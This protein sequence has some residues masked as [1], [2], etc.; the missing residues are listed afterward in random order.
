MLVNAVILT[1]CGLD[2]MEIEKTS[3]LLVHKS[4]TLMLPYSW[5]LFTKKEVVGYARNDTGWARSQNHYRF[6]Y[7]NHDLLVCFNQT[8]SRFLEINLD[9]KPKK[10]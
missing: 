10:Q 6:Q 5:G 1:Y 3:I 7:L 2:W 4:V 9:G 8:E